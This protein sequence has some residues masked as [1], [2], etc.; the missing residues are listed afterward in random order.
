MAWKDTFAANAFCRHMPVSGRQRVLYFVS[1]VLIPVLFAVH[2]VWLLIDPSWRFVG[3]SA[4]Q[5]FYGGPLSWFLFRRSQGLEA[6]LFT[7]R[8]NPDQEEAPE[9]KLMDLLGLGFAVLLLVL[10]PYFWIF[11]K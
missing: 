9:R 4:L 1:I 5:V 8:T 11:G 6:V 7:S 10:P 2:F 3:M